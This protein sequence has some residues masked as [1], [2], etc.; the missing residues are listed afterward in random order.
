[1][2]NKLK[3]KILAGFMLLV[4]FLVVAGTISII[5]FKHLS[6]SVHA[7][8]ENNYLSI[9]ASR[10][11]LESLEREDSG[12]LL[13]MLGQWEKGRDIIAS[14]DSAFNKALSVAETNITE[15]N[16]EMYIDTIRTRYEAYKNEWE[17]PITDTDKQGN[18]SW[19]YNDIHK[20][21]LE[22]K[23]SVDALM[24]L[25]QNN[26]NEKAS[27]L[28]EKS[29]R[30]IMPG[31][32]AIIGAVIFSLLLNFF[33]TKYIVSPINELTQAVRKYQ[34]GEKQL[35]SYIKSNDEIKILENEIGNLI[36]KLVRRFNTNA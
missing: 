12:V 26:M 11:M 16:E 17:K 29:H 35:Q 7:M 15:H 1:M 2:I 27:E 14:A 10:T 18:I 6:G 31:I 36:E 23:K 5:E 13:L 9:E 3:F 25:N 33:I 4:A 21:F 20:Y 28:K 24:V 34:Y 32:V 19:Y 22:A 8:I 30:S